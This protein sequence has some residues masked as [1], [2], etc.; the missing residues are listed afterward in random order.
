M[1]LS[2]VIPC[3]NEVDNIPPL[4]KSICNSLIAD[5]EIILVD[6]GSTDNTPKIL[7]EQLK[8][9]NLSSIR[10]VRVDKNIGYGNGIMKG[11]WEAK[12]EII[13]WTHADLQTDIKDVYKGL[14]IFKNQSN[15]VATFVKGSRKKRFFIDNILTWSMSKISS[16]ALGVKL[17]DINAQPKMFNKTFLKLVDNPPNDFSLDLYFYYTAAINNIQI[18]DFPVYFKERIHGVAKG[19]GG[20]NIRTR[21][22]VIIRTLR[23]IIKVHKN[24]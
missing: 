17:K 18:L 10:S 19:G 20:S 3:Y 21:M 9:I 24:K 5:T 2:I 14:E 12:G 7:S 16:I 15:Q 6:N 4:I 8:S 23:Y 22:K 1:K 11:V 13:A